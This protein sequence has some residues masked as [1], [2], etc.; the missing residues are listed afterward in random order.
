[1][2]GSGRSR[3]Y[4]RR[5]TGLVTTIKAGT[6]TTTTTAKRRIHHNGTTVAQLCVTAGWPAGE[7]GGEHVKKMEINFMWKQ[8][9]VFSRTDVI[10]STPVVPPPPFLLS[11]ATSAPSLHCPET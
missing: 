6:T 1:M 2:L 10:N 3:P 5:A 11:P 9:P 4:V 8:L 7:F